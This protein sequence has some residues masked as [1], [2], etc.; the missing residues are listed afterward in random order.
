MTEKTLDAALL[1]K[2]PL[3]VEFSDPDLAAVAA[4]TQTRKFSK[5]AVLVYEG[6]PGD[7]LFIVIHGNVAVTR[8]SNDGKE[9]ILSILKSGDFFGEMGVLD[10]SPRSATIKALGEAHVAVLARDDFLDL[11]GKSPQMGV[12][13]VLALSGRLRATNQAMQAAA[14][15]DIRTRLASL[16]INLQKNFGEQTPAGTRLTLRLTNQEMANMVGTTRETVNRMLNRFWD[17]KLIDMKTA[18]I[19]VTDGDR[20]QALLG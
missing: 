9:T 17:E 10:A 5:H 19:V 6:D 18:N 16:L 4:L 2:V 13:L 7:S 8:V 11:L 1:K 15:Q 14:Y 3:F 12:S 20:L